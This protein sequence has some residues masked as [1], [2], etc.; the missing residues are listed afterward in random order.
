VHTW[1]IEK[2]P[3]YVDS[4]YF[5]IIW[6]CPSLLISWILVSSSFVVNNISSK[7]VRIFLWV[8]LQKK[9]CPRQTSPPRA[10]PLIGVY[11]MN[12]IWAKSFLLILLLNRCNSERL[13]LLL[14]KVKWNSCTL[15]RKRNRSTLLPRRVSLSLCIFQGKSHGETQGMPLHIQK[16]HP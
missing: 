6:N 12:T 7:L 10:W 9:N 15:G 3:K 1:Q 2:R 8:E 16:W 11:T 4:T 5:G 14:E 13:L